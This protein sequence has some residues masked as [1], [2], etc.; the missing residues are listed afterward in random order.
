M[1]AESVEARLHQIAQGLLGAWMDE[2]MTWCEVR[3]SASAAAVW[4]HGSGLVL[5]RGD[6]AVYASLRNGTGTWDD[7]T[8]SGTGCEA[9]SAR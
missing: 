9:D 7:Q 5:G 3:H 6:V 4:R 2:A 1:S 8:A